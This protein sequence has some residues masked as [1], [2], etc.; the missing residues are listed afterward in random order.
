MARAIT[1]PRIATPHGDQTW[2]NSPRD[3]L[4][5]FQ[6]RYL[7]K[8]AHSLKPSVFVGEAGVS[9]G[10][11]GALDRALSDH[12]LVKV[13]LRDAQDRKTAAQSI[14]DRSGAE[15]CG[16]VGRN[17]VLYRANPDNSSIVLPEREG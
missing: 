9:E 11:L 8:L 12:E 6:R 1:T 16:L 17:L 13:R 10:V 14:A 15:L 5:G 7:R 4:A 2:M 3:S